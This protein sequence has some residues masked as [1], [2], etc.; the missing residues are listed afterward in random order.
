MEN[1]YMRTTLNIDD[2]ILVTAQFLARKDRKTVGKGIS[3]LARNSLI[4]SPWDPSPA[5]ERHSERNLLERRLA[6]LGLVPFKGG[7]GVTNEI[8]DEMRE[9]EGI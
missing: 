5:E 9:T 6:E 8:V 7:G 2:D 4:G 1:I 3:E